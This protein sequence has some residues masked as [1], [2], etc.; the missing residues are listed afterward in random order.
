MHMSELLRH[1]DQGALDMRRVDGGREIRRMI[2]CQKLLKA[3]R[4]LY[5]TSLLSPALK[6]DCGKLE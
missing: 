6:R 5:N 2:P 3:S 1:A 4:D